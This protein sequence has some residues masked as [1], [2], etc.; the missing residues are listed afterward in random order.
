MRR[1]APAP[2]APA[3]RRGPPAAAGARPGSPPALEIDGSVNG[4]VA[5]VEHIDLRLRPDAAKV[6]R[7]DSDRYQ[8]HNQVKL[9]LLDLPFLPDE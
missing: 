1:R 2:S 6:V 7:L 4:R 9:S 8:R 5:T 3:L